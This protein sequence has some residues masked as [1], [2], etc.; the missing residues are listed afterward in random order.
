MATTER[1]LRTGEDLFE[2]PDDGL[3]H[4]LIEGVRQTAGSEGF[5]GGTPQTPGLHWHYGGRSRRTTV[6]RG[7]GVSAG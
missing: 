4:E 1:R 5:L 6:P 3:R 7:W 2:L